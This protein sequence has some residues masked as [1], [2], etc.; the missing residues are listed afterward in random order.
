MC[1][2]VAWACVHHHH[3]TCVWVRGQFHEQK[4]LFYLSKELRSWE[5]ETKTFIR[6][7]IYLIAHSLSPFSLGRNV[8][9]DDYPV[10][11]KDQVKKSHWL[12]SLHIC[13]AARGQLV[14]ASLAGP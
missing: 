9:P 5:L 4:M 12:K 7:D 8:N 1:A 3:L 6:S 14:Q 2:Y 10:A 13:W 11:M